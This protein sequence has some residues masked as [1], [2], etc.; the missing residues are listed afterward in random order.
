MSSWLELR[1]LEENGK[2]VGGTS[3]ATGDMRLK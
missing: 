3:K 1:K 2:L